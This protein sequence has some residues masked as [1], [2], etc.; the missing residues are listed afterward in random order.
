MD[1]WFALMLTNTAK[2][3]HV[4]MTGNRVAIEV[5]RECF[6]AAGIRVFSQAL[7][8]LLRVGETLVDIC[9]TF[10]VLA[11]GLRPAVNDPS[12][13]MGNLIQGGCQSV[14]YFSPL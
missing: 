8:D 1:G 2:V 3:L 12:V 6:H 5:I 4:S 11:F 7:D 14:D 13:Q 9:L 10:F